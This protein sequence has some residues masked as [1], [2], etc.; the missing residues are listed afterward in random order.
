VDFLQKPFSP[1]DI[2]E[3]ATQVLEREA[4]QEESAADYPTLIALTKRHISDRKFDLASASARQAIA[5]DPGQPEVYNLL[6]ALLEI[7][8]DWLEAQKFYRAALDI[9][10]TYQPARANLER[11]ASFRVGTIDLGPDD[12]R[13]TP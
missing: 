11:T 7:Q 13:A 6:G 1:G 10:P 9:D 4:L 3:L 8:G 12:Q 5:S 2:R